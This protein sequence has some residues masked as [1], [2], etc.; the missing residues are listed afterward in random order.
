MRIPS[1]IIL[2]LLLALARAELTA[3]DTA[4]L[5]SLIVF[6]IDF[7]SV[8]LKEDY[9]RKWLRNASAMGYNAV[10]WEVEGKIKWETCPECVSPDAYSKSTFRDILDYSRSLGLEVIPLLQTVGHAEY[11]L[12]HDK[13]SHFKEDPERYDCYATCNP[14]LRKFIRKW[15][16]EYLDL[17]GPVR[18][19]HLGG[20]E[21]YEFATSPGCAK[22][23][24][25]KGKGG[26]FAEYV[27]DIAQ[28][29]LKKG[30]R[31]CIWNDQIM[32]YPE[33]ISQ[34]PNSFVFWDWNYWD[35]DSV[36][37]S[38][39][40]WDK[41]QRLSRDKLDASDLE[42][43][44]EI[45][46]RYGNLR[47]FYTADALKRLGYDVVLCSS[48]RSSGDGVFAVRQAYHASNIIGAAR[49]TARE[50]LLGNCVTSWAIRI[51]SYETQAILLDLAP[52][53]LRNDT[54]SRA[55]LVCR[56]FED[57]F[58]SCAKGFIEALE[59]ISSPFPFADGRSTGI[60]W[61]GMKDSRP[62]PPG[63]IKQMIS[64]WKGGD[65]GIPWGEN[66]SRI[67]ASGGR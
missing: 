12:Q 61:T 48:A 67:N 47:P 14:E 46:D 51:P 8:A 15:I 27:S 56:S 53:T 30:I 57:I 18:Y 13:Y 22:W 3:G 32:Q 54:L 19:F 44:P 31:P 16:E 59:N 25:E 45:I 66:A 34:I 7:N 1:S 37:R 41:G 42:H 36:P 60:Q 55:D 17:F 4:S 2:P 64:D 38:V 9:L 29:L 40:V 43:Y 10:L 62:A 33:A 24:K 35:G 21:A 20:D 23:V 63:Y 50:H 26:L 52:L 5:P 65:K 6:H 58:G 28:P 39:M 49:K 11:V